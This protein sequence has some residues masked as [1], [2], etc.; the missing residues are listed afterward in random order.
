MQ[1]SIISAMR[2]CNGRQ[3]LGCLQPRR[4]QCQAAKDEGIEIFTVTAMSPGHVSSTLGQE[5]TACASST[6][7]AFLNNSDANV[8]RDAFSNIAASL[9]PLRLTH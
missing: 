5:L 8:L 3:S 9:S 4:D 1:G 7:H 6:A 2:P